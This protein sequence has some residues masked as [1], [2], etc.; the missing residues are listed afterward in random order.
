MLRQK[1]K[2]MH[3]FCFKKEFLYYSEIL[4]S[5]FIIHDKYIFTFSKFFV[6][7]FYTFTLNWYKFPLI[8][9]SIDAIIYI[10]DDYV[11]KDF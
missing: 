5:F 7:I 9:I 10:G 8:F 1:M 4:F 6:K 11:K 2:I 3:S